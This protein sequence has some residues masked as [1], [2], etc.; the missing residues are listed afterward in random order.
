MDDR[1]HIFDYIASKFELKVT[2]S[3]TEGYV[4]GY[5]LLYKNNCNVGRC[6]TYCGKTLLIIGYFACY[7]DT[8]FGNVRLITSQDEIIAD[9][10]IWCWIVGA[11]QRPIHYET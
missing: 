5:D 1:K 6:V 9:S 8:L 4:T 2:N 11:I 10:T 7:V 3:T